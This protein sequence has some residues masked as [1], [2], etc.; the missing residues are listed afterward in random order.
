M[1]RD[2]RQ[3]EHASH[4]T[5]TAIED[6]STIATNSWVEYDVTSFVTGT[7]TYSFRLATT[8]TDGVDIY[9]RENATLRPELVVTLR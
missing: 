9:S 6:K 8:S 7:G 1:E 4:P 3:L 5:S 2:H